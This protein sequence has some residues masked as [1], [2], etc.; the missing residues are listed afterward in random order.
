M[1][2]DRTGSWS[3]TT[4]FTDPVVLRKTIVFPTNETSH[5]GRT[6]PAVISTVWPLSKFGSIAAGAE[7]GAP[8]PTVL[9]EALPAHPAA[10]AAARATRQ[11]RRVTAFRVGT[12]RGSGRRE[13]A[14][15]SAE[16]SSPG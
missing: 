3:N 5:S 14:A 1:G 7:D 15:S 13:A 4:R 12:G 11:S 16:A 6:L 10:S 8:L 2:P 9:P